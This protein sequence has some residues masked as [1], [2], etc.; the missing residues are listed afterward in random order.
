MNTLCRK[1]I[2]SACLRKAVAMI[3]QIRSHGDLHWDHFSAP[4]SVIYFVRI[5][6]YQD[7][8]AET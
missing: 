7:T 1:Y 8:D 2:S 5:N 6:Y 3:Y 4:C